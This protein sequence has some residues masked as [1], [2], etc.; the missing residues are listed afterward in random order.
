MSEKKKRKWGDRK[1]GTWVRD[2]PG[3]LSIMPHLMPNRTDAEVYL[4]DTYD[5]TKLL[6][7]NEDIFNEL[8]D[9][10]NNVELYSDTKLSLARLYSL[11]TKLT[12]A[13]ASKIYLRCGGYLV[14]NHTEALTVIDVNSG[15]NVISRKADNETNILNINLQAAAESAL[16]MKLRN[17][18]GMILIDFINMEEETSREALIKAMEDAVSDDYVTVKVIDITPLGIMEITRQKIDKPLSEYIDVFL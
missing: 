10:F 17:I 1:D 7:D 4:H 6:T 9:I 16:I 11:K 14:I 8:A 12:E 13:T 2:V 15:K 3:L 5:I 18:T